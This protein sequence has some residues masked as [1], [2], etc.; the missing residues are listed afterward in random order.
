MS[1][2]VEG[3]RWQWPERLDGENGLLVAPN[4]PSALS[5]AISRFASALDGLRT[6]A[7]HDPTFESIVEADLRTGVHRNPDVAS[8]PEWFTL[9]YFHR[10]D[11]LAS[12]VADDT[13]RM[14][15]V[16]CDEAIPGESQLVFALKT[17][18]RSNETLVRV[19]P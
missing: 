15:F 4:D 16:C 6:H 18:N 12:E 11:E 10:P 2:K 17:L 7:I 13:L 9:A 8:K 1:V 14:L 19:R 5:A 3:A